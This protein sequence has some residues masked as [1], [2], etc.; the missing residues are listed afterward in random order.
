LSPT[1][2]E[3]HPEVRESRAGIALAL[4]FLGIYAVL[5]TVYYDVTVHSIEAEHLPQYCDVSAF[6]PM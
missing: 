2:A 1:P 5:Q 4:G 3:R 6:A